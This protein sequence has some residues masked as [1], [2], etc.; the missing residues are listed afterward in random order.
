MA[1]SG[2][3]SLAEVYVLQKLQ[4]EKMKKMDSEST[5]KKELVD[6]EEKDSSGCFSMVF[7]KVHPTGVSSTD[8][9]EKLAGKDKDESKNQA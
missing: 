6:D 8:S 2:S 4:K 7:K 5:T 9:A 3:A 1:L